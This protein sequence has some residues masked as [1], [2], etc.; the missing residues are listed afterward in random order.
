MKVKKNI[1][2]IFFFVYTIDLFICNNTTYGVTEPIFSPC[3]YSFLY[4]VDL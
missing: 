1:Y 2:S 4:C 3:N